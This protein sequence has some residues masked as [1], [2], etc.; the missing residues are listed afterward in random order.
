[1]SMAIGSSADALS[2][3]R[4][5]LQ[6]VA[7]TA[8]NVAGVGPVGDLLSSLTGSGDAGSGPQTGGLAPAPSQFRS[9]T[10]AA[11]IA[12]QAG[13]SHGSAG[14]Q[15]LF[16]QIDADGDGGISQ[17]EFETAVGSSGVDA[18]SAD[19]LFAKLDANGDGSVSPGELHGARHH[20]HGH[21]HHG[22]TTEDGDAAQGAGQAGAGGGL[23]SLLD[24]ASANGAQTQTVSNADGSSTTTI[25]YADGSTVSMTTPAAPADAT[26]TDNTS[27]GST[28][29]NANGVNLIEQLIRMQAQLISQQGATV[30]AVA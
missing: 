18:S 4:S 12:L 27:G 23:A 16:A 30:S 22:M 25:T 29:A 17:G 15:S 28:V 7:N 9:G 13:H 2:S 26:S 14:R 24:S 11:L 5:L 20:G 3:I 10:M 1:M 19:A 6:S 8:G 21:H